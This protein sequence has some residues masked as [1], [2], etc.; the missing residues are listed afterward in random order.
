VTLSLALRHVG[1]T[2]AQM[3]FARAE[4]LLNPS[5]GLEHIGTRIDRWKQEAVERQIQEA[6]KNGRS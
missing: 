6:L 1:L 4:S 3:S 5:E 2:D